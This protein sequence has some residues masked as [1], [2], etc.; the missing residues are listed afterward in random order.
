MGDFDCLGHVDL[1]KRYAA[2]QGMFVIGKENNAARL[3]Q[4]TLGFHESIRRNGKS[5]RSEVI[6]KEII[7]ES[8]D[9]PI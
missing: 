7:M 8:I 4:E 9:S 6:K 1:I 5:A 3:D 2:G